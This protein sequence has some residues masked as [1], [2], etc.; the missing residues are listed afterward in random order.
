MSGRVEME[1]EID[2]ED[3]FRVISR[4]QNIIEKKSTMPILSTVLLTAESGILSV[5]AT[6]LEMGFQQKLPVTINKEGSVTIP[7]R[8]IFEIL[9]ESSSEKISLKE[10]DNNW[11]FISDGN[12]RYNLASFSADE[13]PG[14]VEPE[15][16]PEIEIEG[17]VLNEMIDKTIYAV[18]A[19][20]AGY[21]LSGIFTEIVE[22]EQGKML[23]MVATDGHRLSLIDKHVENVE[24]LDLPSGI[25]IP[26][27]AMIEISKIGSES[28][29]IH[30]GFKNKYCVVRKE[31][32]ILTVRLLESKFPDYSMVIPKETP[33]L[34]NLSKNI[35]IESMRRMLILSNERYRAVKMS[36]EGDKMELVSTNPDVGDVQENLDVSYGGRKMEIGFNPKYFVDALQS[37]ESHNITLGFKDESKPCILKGEADAGFLA[38]MMPMRI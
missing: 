19:E 8:K 2:R 28:E 32:L 4:V 10:K 33:I 26:R 14:L 25:M 31:N 35:L 15:D 36:F 11:I 30:F 1:V 22:G 34:L 27:K 20:D 18:T 24:A 23:R 37:M 7:G 3:L 29:K 6:D 12:A 13:F 5:S 17:R 21:K 38:L 16:V 9:R